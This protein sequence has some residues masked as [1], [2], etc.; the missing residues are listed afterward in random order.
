RSQARPRHKLLAYSIDASVVGRAVEIGGAS[1]A[2]RP[3]H[4]LAVVAGLRPDAVAVVGAARHSVSA[5][6]ADADLADLSLPA[7]LVAGA[8]HRTMAVAAPV[9]AQALRLSV[10]SGPIAFAIAERLE[11]TGLPFCR[12]AAVRGRARLD[13]LEPVG[14]VVV[15]PASLIAQ[16]LVQLALA[17]A[18]R[19]REERGERALPHLNTSRKTVE[20]PAGS[21]T[22]WA[23]KPL[24]MRRA[25][26]VRTFPGPSSIKV[27]TPRS[28]ICWMVSTQRT[29]AVTCVSSRGMIR[30]GSVFGSAVAFAITGAFGWRIW[31]PPSTSASLGCTGDIK[32]QWKGALTGSGNARL[33]PFALQMAIARS[34]AGA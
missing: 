33:A 22:A 16:L 30:S 13:A 5:F 27:S 26:P 14:A 17:L 20:R 24:S 32:E 2:G 28:T 31:K 11:L 29:G 9:R 15:S 12:D 18:R 6:V 34:T 10:G 25:S 3:G 1:H 4:A 23:R 19:E 21:S 7:I 8:L